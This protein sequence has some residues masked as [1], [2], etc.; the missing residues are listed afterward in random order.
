MPIA[1]SPMAPGAAPQQGLAA[2]C[3][4]RFGTLLATLLAIGFTLRFT[5]LGAQSLWIDE[6]LSYGWIDAI[7]RLGPASLLYDIH[8]PLHA[9]AIYATSQVSTSEWWLRFPSAVA[10]TL[11]IPALALFGRALW[12]SAVGLVAAALLTVSPFALYYS[13]EC[14]N[15]AFTILFACLLGWAALAFARAPGMRRAVALAA[16]ELGA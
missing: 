5:R 2:A 10:G 7:H 3:E 16:A 6:V 15:Y 4:R 13:Q 11:A 9:L 1:S 12:G 8:G 14:R